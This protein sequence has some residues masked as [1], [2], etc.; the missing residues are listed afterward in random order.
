MTITEARRNVGKPVI[1]T[2]SAGETKLGEIVMIVEP[3]VR[4]RYE[5]SLTA[6]ST[7]PKQLELA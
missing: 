7:S 6:K 5:G 4:V 1:Y 2:D 3:W